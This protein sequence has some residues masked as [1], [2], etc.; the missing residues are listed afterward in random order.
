MFK[1]HSYFQEKTSDE[2]GIAG[3]HRHWIAKNENEVDNLQYQKAAEQLTMNL[4]YLVNESKDSDVVKMAQKLLG[5][6]KA[7]IKIT[8]SGVAAG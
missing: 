1:L 3:F 8:W 2:W 4:Q 7:S 5:Q 6:S